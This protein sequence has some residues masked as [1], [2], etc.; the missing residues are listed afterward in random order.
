MS[1]GWK[2]GSTRA[3]RQLRAARLA[4]D[5]GQCQ[6]RLARCTGVATTVHHLDGVKRGLIV[7][8]D[9]LVAACAWCNGH[10]GDPDKHN[11]KPIK[12]TVW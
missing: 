1:A 5:R 7:P 12:W 2:G 3:W 4:M 10:V 11:P 6:L 9:R 8:L